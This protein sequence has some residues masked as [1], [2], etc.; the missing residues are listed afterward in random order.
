VRPPATACARTSPN[1]RPP[2]LLAALTALAITG[3][4]TAPPPPA[5]AAAAPQVFSGRLAL[6]V[7]APP[8]AEVAPSAARS[9]SGLFELVGSASTGRLTLSTPLGATL[10]EARWSPQDARLVAAEGE[11]HYRNLD[12]LTTDLVG[13][14]LPIGALFDWLGGRPAAGESSRSLPDTDGFEQF[15]WRVELGRFADGRLRL[16]RDGR[17]RVEL[18]LVIDAA[19]NP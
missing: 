19:P 16:A 5:T 18:R 12:A 4:A 14:P 15:G 13:E 11:R 17:L 10:A 1:A 6:T 2:R 9:A 3:C 8:A 7:T